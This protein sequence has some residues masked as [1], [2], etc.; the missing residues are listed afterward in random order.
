MTLRGH[1]L[2]HNET[3]QKD[4]TYMSMNESIK[5]PLEMIYFKSHLYQFLGP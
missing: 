4:Y 2:I 1:I 3:G 5:R